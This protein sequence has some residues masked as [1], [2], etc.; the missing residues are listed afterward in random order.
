MSAAMRTPTMT[1]IENLVSVI[2]VRELDPNAPS[3]AVFA[4]HDDTFLAQILVKL[5]AEHL[6]EVGQR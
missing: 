1:K 3:V 2:Q 5:A 6:T 4:K